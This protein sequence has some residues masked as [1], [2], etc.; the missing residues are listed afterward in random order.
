LGYPVPEFTERRLRATR[1][2]MAER[3]CWEAMFDLEPLALAPFPKVVVNGTWDNAPA[4]YRESTGDA[5]IACGAFIAERVGARL[6]RV[7]GAGHLTH[8]DQPDFVNGLLRELWRA[9]A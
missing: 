7:P 4:G 8:Q 1:T 6:V 3:P 2:A 5:L 9:E